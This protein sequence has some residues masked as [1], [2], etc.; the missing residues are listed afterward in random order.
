MLKNQ[1]AHILL[2]RPTTTK[3]K[4]PIAS[5]IKYSLSWRGIRCAFDVIDLNTSDGMGK[6][7]N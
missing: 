1:Q 5:Q 6:V 2:S 7:S 3:K 4:T